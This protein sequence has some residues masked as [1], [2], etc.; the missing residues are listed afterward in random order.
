[1]I[2]V[3]LRGLIDAANDLGKELT[4]QVGKHDTQGT[5]PAGDETAGGSVRRVAEPTADLAHPLASL[6]P[7][8]LAAVG[9]GR[10]SPPTR[11]PRA[12]PSDRDH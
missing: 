2:A 12:R 8:E 5:G 7:D 1:M 10:L 6:F 11:R 4:V 9:P 3:S